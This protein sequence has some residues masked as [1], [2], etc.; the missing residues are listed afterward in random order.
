MR[1][2]TEI[3][4]PSLSP[5]SHPHRDLLLKAAKC[6]LYLPGCVG[7]REI[8]RARIEVDL[9]PE[10]RP[11]PKLVSSEL[12]R[13]VKKQFLFGPRRSHCSYLCSGEDAVLHKVGP[14]DFVKTK[15]STIPARC[16]GVADN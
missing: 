11:L 8:E 3:A 6:V 12:T 1:W 2:H 14:S 15:M 7:T 10:T 13:W 9:M 4:L 16:S 5:S